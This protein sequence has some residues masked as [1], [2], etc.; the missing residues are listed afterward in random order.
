MSDEVADFFFYTR[1]PLARWLIYVGSAAD[2][3]ANP[4][5]I[6]GLDLISV[7]DVMAATINV[8]GG[9]HP[10]IDGM[11]VDPPIQ[12]GVPYRRD[13]FMQK[14]IRLLLWLELVTA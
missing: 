7:R 3:A 13:E 9:E 5:V 2:V 1:R 10:S 6:G 8:G 12:I 4:N 11:D 14:Y